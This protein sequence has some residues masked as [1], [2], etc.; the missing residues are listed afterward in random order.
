MCTVQYKQNPIIIL[1]CPITIFFMTP[2][3]KRKINNKINEHDIFLN[4]K[5][6]RLNIIKDLSI[7]FKKYNIASATS[8]DVKDLLRKK[9]VN[10]NYPLFIGCQIISEDPL[11]IRMIEI[12]PEA[13]KQDGWTGKRNPF[14]LAC[15]YG[16]LNLLSKLLKIDNTLINENDMDGR[17][18]LFYAC[19]NKRLDVIRYLIKHALINVNAKDS[20]QQT[21]F[22][23][24]CDLCHLEVC[25]ELL[26]NEKLQGEAKDKDGN[27]PLFSIV[28][29]MMQSDH[30]SNCINSIAIIKKIIKKFPKSLYNHTKDGCNILHMITRIH[31]NDTKIR[32]LYWHFFHQLITF[33]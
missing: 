31:N 23:Y 11:C 28:L 15:A 21:A 6:R 9:D 18:P 8:V 30:L 25:N 16:K 3:K 12:F 19:K 4:E 24:S 5:K 33:L 1:I 20:R 26:K 14:H 22:H 32:D 13:I 29:S 17:T 7:F 10:G 27:T 2:T